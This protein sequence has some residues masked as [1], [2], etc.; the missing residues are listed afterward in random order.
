ME[1]SKDVLGVVQDASA[2]QSLLLTILEALNTGVWPKTFFMFNDLWIENVKSEIAQTM[3][4]KYGVSVPD[5][6][7]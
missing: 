7:L 5:S 6:E 2:M 1:T 4:D 3:K